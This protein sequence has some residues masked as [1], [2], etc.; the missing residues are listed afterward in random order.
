MPQSVRPG[1]GDEKRFDFGSSESPQPK[2]RKYPRQES[3]APTLS[4]DGVTGIE[5]C[6]SASGAQTGAPKPDFVIPTTIDADLARL[7]DVWPT[8]TDRTRREIC[9][10][11]NQA[12]C[13]VLD[14]N[15]QRGA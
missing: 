15:K 1:P 6:A 14:T 10:L 4:A 9:D 3:N 13:D 8:L 5:N 11:L 7:I 12:Q 2:N